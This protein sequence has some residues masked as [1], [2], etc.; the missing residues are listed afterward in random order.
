[1]IRRPP[2]ST[3]FPYTTLF[4]SIVGLEELGADAERPLDGERRLE[5]RSHRGRDAD[6][7]S[8]AHVAR[9]ATDRVAEALEDAERA[10]DHRARLGRG[11]ELADDSDRA[12]GASCSEEPAL[13]HEHPP[14]ADPGQMEGDR[15]ARDAPPDDDDVGGA[16]HARVLRLLTA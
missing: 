1:M 2:R 3:L 13:E 14:E 7:R 5:L 8:A 6:Q 15:G 16:R 11:V 12:A 9:L 4:R 10:Q